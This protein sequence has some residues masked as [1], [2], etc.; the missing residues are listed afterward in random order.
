LIAGASDPGQHA[1]ADH[2]AFELG[3]DAHHL[4]H[5]PAGGRGGIKALLMQEQ[6]NV[7][8]MKLSEEPEPPKDC[9]W[10]D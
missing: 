2:G 7:F 5:R 1:L 3:K 8:G 10:P 9:W 6:I 4:E